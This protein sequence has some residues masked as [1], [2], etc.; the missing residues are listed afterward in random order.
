MMFLSYRSKRR[1]RELLY[2]GLTAVTAC[3]FAST[4]HNSTHRVR[5]CSHWYEYEYESR[6]RVSVYGSYK[7]HPYEWS[8][9]GHYTSPHTSTCVYRQSPV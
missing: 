7:L 8:V 3:S 1:T 4:Q 6:V 5:L 9:H 2:R